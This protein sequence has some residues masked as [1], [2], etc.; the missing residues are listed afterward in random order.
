MPRFTDYYSDPEV[1]LI[2]EKFINKY[3]SIFEGFNVDQMNVVYTKGKKAKKPIRVIPV[4]YPYDVYVNKPY[5]VEVFETWWAKLSQVQ[6]NLAVFHVMCAIPKGGFDEQSS[7]YAKKAKP[8]IEMY[9]TEF[10]ASGG[11]PN[12]LENPSASDPME[13][14]DEEMEDVVSSSPSAVKE[15]DADEQA[16]PDEVVRVPLTL[17]DVAQV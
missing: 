14:E 4:R 8:D 2:M 13:L 1:K 5:I 15:D 12:W 16:I 3:P 9:L 11:I 17:N 7:H 6:K 10:V